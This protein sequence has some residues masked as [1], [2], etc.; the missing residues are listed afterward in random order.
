LTAPTSAA[1][2]PRKLRVGVFADSP[3]QPRWLVESLA[4]IATSDFAEICVL[5][6]AE[7]RGDAPPAL[8][9]TYKRVDR[10]LFG[11]PDPLKP[12]PVQSLVPSSKRV[13]FE[14]DDEAWRSRIGKLGLD[15]AVTLGSLDDDALQDLAWYGAWRYSFGETQQAAPQLAAL[16]EVIGEQPV[17]ASGIHIRRGIARRMAC[18]SYSRTIPFSLA[19]SHDRLF[20]KAG[21]FLERS[22]RHLHAEGDGWLERQQ[23]PEKP[24]ALATLGATPALQGIATLG[25]R[26]IK[27]TMES[28]FT[29][30]QWSLAFR[31]AAAEPWDGNLEGFHRLVPPAPDRFWADPFPIEVQG[32]HYIF[33]EELPFATG[34]GHI[35]VVEVRP[36]GSASPPRR[37]LERDYHLSYPFLVEDAGELYMIP[38]TAYN[39]TVEI[40]R[41]EEFPHRWRLERVLIDGVFCADATVHRSRGREAP[42]METDTRWWM[43]ANLG[44]EEAGF[45]DELHLFSSDRLLGDWKPHGANPVKSDVRSSRPAGRL[46]ARDGHLYRPG[47][48]CTPIYG[49]GVALHRVTQLSPERFTEDEERRIVPRD[50]EILGMHTINR[51][52]ELSV[53]DTFARRRRF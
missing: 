5:S 47:Q 17:V 20:G 13:P 38:E 23:V 26:V 37:V 30:G 39:N 1:A 22:L 7:S 25:A 40:Y 27:R 6:A 50:P 34:K 21:E 33:F 24:L 19:R 18:P 4:R 46:F 43:F 42:S 2:V 49:S 31:F 48:I 29:V 11:G 32:R 28:C 10:W 14:P 3:R 53:T 44:N 51:A 15:V 36:D 9:N 41:C 12:L 52:G 16:R 35:S 8:W 45:D